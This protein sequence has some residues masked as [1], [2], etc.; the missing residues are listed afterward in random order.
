MCVRA[1]GGGVGWGGGVDRD[2]TLTLLRT[3]LLLK[4]SDLVNW[5]GNSDLAEGH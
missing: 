3:E 2:A 5:P 4:I 1:G